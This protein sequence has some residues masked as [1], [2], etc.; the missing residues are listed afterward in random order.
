M[1]PPTCDRSQS[2]GPEYFH[3]SV[4]SWGWARTLAGNQQ[5]FGWFWDG[6]VGRAAGRELAAPGMALLA[7]SVWLGAVSG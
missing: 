7:A 6:R 1:P 3:R 2:R 5:A 4:G